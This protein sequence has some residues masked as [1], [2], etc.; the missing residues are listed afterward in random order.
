MNTRTSHLTPRPGIM[1][2]SPYVGGRSA[3]DGRQNVIRLA[4]NES[5]LGP[6]PRAVAAYE[7]LG[8]FERCGV[9]LRA[10]EGG[11]A[12]LADLLN[13]PP[14][15]EDWFSTL[16]QGAALH[17]RGGL[18]RPL[19]AIERMLADATLLL[20]SPV[21]VL[22]PAD[23]GWTLRAP[24][25]RAL[26]Q[27]DAVVLACG[28][29]LKQFDPASF[30]PIE[31]SRGQIEWG[32][33]AA[34]ARAITRGSYVAP[35]DG[36]VLFGATFDRHDGKTT[37]IE[38]ARARNLNTLR[39]L[40]P[41]IAA[42]LN[43][44]SLR[45]RASDRATTPDRAPVAGLLPDSE[46]WL[47]QYAKLATGQVIACDAPPPAHDGVYVIGGLGARGLTMAPLL[48]EV[49]AAEMC[50]EPALLSQIARDAIHPARFLHRA[51]KRR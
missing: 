1:E 8:A 34:P 24:D 10:L 21:Q 13:D 50:G 32:E 41:E 44:A 33:G 15:P 40:A 4:A 43:D 23:S 16:R 25:G 36:G 49:I 39:D 2:I 31:L 47:E 12:A 28:A 22:E 45:S 51:L 20:E 35:L 46:A 9:E 14:L 6:S 17:A 42:S 5:A 27:A 29:G 38:D 11:E 48:G 37:S 30:L 3:L 26:L 7:A 19:A 18:V